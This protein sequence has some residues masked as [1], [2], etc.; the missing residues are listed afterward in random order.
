MRWTATQ[1]RLRLIGIPDWSVISDR[2]VTVPDIVCSMD[3]CQKPVWAFGLC[4]MHYQR[5]RKHGDPA[6]GA[7]VMASDMIEVDGVPSRRCRICG[8]VKPMG[9]FALSPT[10]RYGRRGDCKQCIAA[11]EKR[12]WPHAGHR[13]SRDA[14]YKRDKRL[15]WIF[16]IS[17]SDY[18]AMLLD[19]NGLC[20]ICREPQA[21]NRR[22]GDVLVVDHNHATGKVR[23]LL[24]HACNQALGLFQDDPV[25]MQD[26][27]AYVLRHAAVEVKQDEQ[28]NSGG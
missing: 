3:A 19:Q 4:T 28:A 13:P 25:R 15:R 2:L 7:R 10:S 24:C 5:K 14:A 12:N 18:S 17:L 16:G 26:A 6:V 11:Q 22:E 1:D 20:G 27:L 8:V 23:G 21:W 9:D